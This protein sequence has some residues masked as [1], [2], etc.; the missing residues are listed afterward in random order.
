MR[1]QAIMACEDVISV[2]TLISGAANTETF[3]ISGRGT[4]VTGTLE[5]GI[6]KKGDEC[7]FVGHNRSFKSVVTGRWKC[8]ILSPKSKTHSSYK[9]YTEQEYVPTSY[10]CP[11]PLIS[12]L[13]MCS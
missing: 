2:R 5:R 8:Q 4:V 6:V 13:C 9:I 3:L 7:E 1:R 10:K 11:P 12:S